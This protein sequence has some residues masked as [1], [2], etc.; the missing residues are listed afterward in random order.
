V[1]IRLLKGA[2]IFATNLEVKMAKKTQN[3]PSTVSKKRPLLLSAKKQIS[4]KSAIVEGFRDTSKEGH[5]ERL[6]RKSYALTSEEAE[7]IQLIKEKCLNRRVLLSDSQVIRLGIKL[8]AR[9]SEAELVKEFA[10]VP[11]MS[12][13]RPRKG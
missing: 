9:L 1:L 8:A 11:K 5:R 6:I 10:Q 3:I 4:K 7:N 12:V 2:K 13:G